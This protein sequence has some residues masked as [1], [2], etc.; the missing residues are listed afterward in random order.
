[1]R[2]RTCTASFSALISSTTNSLGAI[3]KVPTRDPVKT[4]TQ[5]PNASQKSFRDKQFKD[6]RVCTMNKWLRNPTAPT[7][8]YTK[9]SVPFFPAS[10]RSLPVCYLLIQTANIHNREWNFAHV[11]IDRCA[12]VFSSGERTSFSLQCSMVPFSPATW[13]RTCFVVAK[14]CTRGTSDSRSRTDRQEHRKTMRHRRCIRT[15]PAATLHVSSTGSL[16][17]CHRCP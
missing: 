6:Q 11:N 7:R 10:N 15:P 17:S 1:M 3:R 2:K 8:E 12:L 9:S 14:G 16:G 13:K 5:F 4:K